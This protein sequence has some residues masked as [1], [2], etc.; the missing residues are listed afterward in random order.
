MF[1][2]RKFHR[3]DAKSLP[4]TSRLCHNPKSCHAGP[5]AGIQGG[6]IINFK[7]PWIPAFAGMTAREQL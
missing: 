7:P 6:K 3:K 4:R 2:I 5:R 1:K